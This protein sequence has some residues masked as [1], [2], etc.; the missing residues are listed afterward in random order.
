MVLF[1]VKINEVENKQISLEFDE[2][3]RNDASQLEKMY[4]ETI[5]NHFKV[6]LGL[7]KIQNNIDELPNWRVKL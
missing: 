2:L 5:M 6:F 4:S 3:S 7:L 1:Q